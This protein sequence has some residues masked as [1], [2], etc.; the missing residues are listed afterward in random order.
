MNAFVGF[1]RNTEPRVLALAVAETLVYAGM[2]YIFPA[3]LGRWEA[4]FGWS[5]TSLTLALTG[6]L[7][8]AALSAPVAGQVIDRGHGRA[9]MTLSTLAGGLLIG[10]LVL[11]EQQWQFF[12]I[13]AALGVA[14]AGCFYE[15]C[16]AFITHARGLAARKIITSITLIAGFASTVSY[17]L[18]TWLAE[19]VGWRAGAGG[20]A[21]LLLVLGVPLMWFGAASRPGDYVAP[22][23]P[24]ENDDPEGSP[25]DGL[26]AAMRRPVFWLLAF[27][28]SMIALNHGVII[29]HLFPLL[30]DRHVPLQWAVI[31]AMCIGPMQVAG[32]I[33]MVL[34]ERW[35]SAAAVCGLSY[36]AMAVA[37]GS[38]FLA[39]WLPMLIALFVIGQG[40][41][42]GVTSITRPVVTADVLG[43]RQF[44]AISGALALP[45]TGATAAAPILGSLIWQVGGYDAVLKATLAMALA[46]LAAFVAALRLARGS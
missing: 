23:T 34:T 12:V 39:A 2:Y 45:Y 41:G 26:R 31:A 7:V 13:W 46:G 25:R 27:A 29:T 1:F 40:A 38:L 44:G 18:I 6:A 14:F 22:P 5:K 4:E 32:R 30:E 43:R 36:V 3:L 42:I 21:V 19:T 10:L 9:M 16:F 8:A 17:P 24:A 35:L 37:S 33:G 20:A 11:V 28:F 15:P